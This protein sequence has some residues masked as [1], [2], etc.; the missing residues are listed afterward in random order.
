M[1]SFLAA[2][3]IIGIFFL[4]CKSSSRYSYNTGEF[5]ISNF[6][7]EVIDSISISPDRKL[8]KNFIRLNPRE[9][10]QYRTDMSGRAMSDGAFKI[11]FKIRDTHRSEIFGYYSNG[12]FLEKLIRIN[13][14]TDSITYEYVH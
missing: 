13:I 12:S 4:S 6:T 3:I 1:R 14:S 11:N 10:S 5:Q 8:G 9:S 7:P 2:V